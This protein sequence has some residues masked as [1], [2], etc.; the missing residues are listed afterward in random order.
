MLENAINIQNN[1]LHYVKDNNI[2]VTVFLLNG[3]KLVGIVVGFDDYA[4]MLKR[5]EHIQMVYKHAISTFSPHGYVEI[6]AENSKE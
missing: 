5:D 6:N 1:F 4:I 2:S 3:V